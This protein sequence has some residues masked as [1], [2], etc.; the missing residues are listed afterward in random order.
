VARIAERPGRA[1]P[2]KEVFIRDRR[3][4]VYVEFL[5]AF[6][7]LFL[8]FLG[9]CQLALL[10]AAR[11]M[12]SHAAV[13]AVRSAIVILEDP[14]DD[15][16][17]VPRGY[18]S[19]QAPSTTASDPPAGN[20]WRDSAWSGRRNSQVGDL[21]TAAFGP[22]DPPQDGPRMEKIR[23]AALGPLMALAPSGA[24]VVIHSD[25]MI[26]ALAS[27]SGLLIAFASEY[28]T[29]ATAVTVHSSPTD[30]ALAADPIDPKGQVTVRVTYLYRCGIPV[31]RALMCRS[32]QSLLGVS[33]RGDASNDAKRLAD[34]ADP[35][36]IERAM[37]DDDRYTIITG[38]STLPNQG[39]GYVPAEQEQ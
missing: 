31:V 35:G 16:D 25:S 30:P 21:A 10:N 23:S 22:S 37:R 3:G 1:R 4:V 32:L 11:L 17:G 26:R 39:A 28:T 34:F 5:L 15:Y 13:T 6:I 8:L 27:N 36:L 9:T 20:R 14:A 33:E 24:T 7:P 38:L 12:V 19:S 29:A 18:L 2:P